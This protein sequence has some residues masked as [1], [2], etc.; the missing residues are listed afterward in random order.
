MAT[1]DSFASIMGYTDPSNG[2][3]GGYTGGNNSVIRAMVAFSA[4]A[5][6]NSIELIFIICIRFKKWRGLYFWSLMSTSFAIIIYQIGCYGKMN[7]IIPNHPAIMSALTNVG[8][9]V[10]VTGE[11]LVLYSR[12]HL[13]SRDWLLLKSV[14][15]G[16][17]INSFCCYVPTTVWDYSAN[18]VHPDDPVYVRG[19]SIM[20]RV[21]MSL[22]TTQEILISTIYLIEAYRF[23]NVKYVSDKRVRNIMYE[24][25]AV[26]IIIIALDITLLTLAQLEYFAI[27]VTLK[28]LIYSAKLKLEL[29][30]LS[31]L[32]SIVSTG[33]SRI[34][35]T[36][37]HQDNNDQAFGGLD[38]CSSPFASDKMAQERSSEST[39]RSFPPFRR[40][41]TSVP[42]L[43]TSMRV[44]TSVSSA[45]YQPEEPEHEVIHREEPYA[46]TEFLTSA[47]VTEGA[48]DDNIRQFHREI[49]AELSGRRPSGSMSAKG[50]Q[51]RSVP[52]EEVDISRIEK[53]QGVP[54]SP[55]SR[56]AEEEERSRKRELLGVDNSDDGRGDSLVELYPGR[57]TGKNWR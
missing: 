52:S 20:E 3:A 21:Q 48:N 25:L 31:R 46:N 43:A 11:S 54:L 51:H 53:L 23:L 8:W 41:R 28:G 24:L 16:I 50:K 9:I 56:P 38:F 19:Y 36:V 18:V 44:K 22:F 34:Q 7:R 57:I 42:W 12:L 10:M 35:H 13:L 55:K 2:I 5:W 15:W 32:V 27:E 47:A 1:M 40:A 37:T 29:G 4:I 39:I 45:E 49:E 17:I 30:V 14:L 33:G 26:N 6:Y